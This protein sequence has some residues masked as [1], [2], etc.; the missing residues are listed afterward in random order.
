MKFN[1]VTKVNLQAKNV[2]TTLDQLKKKVCFTALEKALFNFL[3]KVILGYEP[4]AST[5]LKT[6][7]TCLLL[8]MTHLTLAFISNKVSLVCQM[9][10][11]NNKMN[12]A[13]Y[14]VS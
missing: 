9:A 2:P 3:K 7:I 5:T 1:K 10:K 13:V 12:S 11:F 4:S 6:R 8:V 14:K